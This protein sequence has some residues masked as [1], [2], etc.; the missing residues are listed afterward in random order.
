[1][2]VLL[3]FAS[4]PEGV[5]AIPKAGNAQHTAQNAQILTERLTEE[6]MAVL[7]RAFPKPTRAMALDIV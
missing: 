5:I 4:Q 7:N 3:A 1:M 6:E 2:Q